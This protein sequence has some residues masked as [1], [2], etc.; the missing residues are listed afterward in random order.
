MKKFISVLAICMMLIMSVAISAFAAE[1]DNSFVLTVCNANSL[2]IEPVRVTYNDGQTIKDALLNSGYEFSGLAEHGYIEAVEGVSASYVILYDGGGY[3]VN[4]EASSIT[5]IRIGVTNVNSAATD[6]MLSMIK[7]VADFVDATNNVQNYPDAKSAYKNCLNAIRGDGL[8]AQTLL[9]ALEAAESAYTAVLNGPKFTVS[10]T[11]LQSGK[12]LPTPTVSLRDSYGNVTT[13]I[14][15]TVSVIAGNYTFSVSDG[16]YN[17]TEGK[18]TV[19]TNTSISTTLP[20]TEWYGDI[21]SEGYLYGETGGNYFDYKVEQD[22][23]N[24]TLKIWVYDFAEGRVGVRLKAV[25]KDVP[26]KDAQRSETGLYAVYTGF[27]GND[28]SQFNHGW[29]GMQNL[30]YVVEAGLE[31]RTFQLEGRYTNGSQT[32]IQSYDVEIIRVPTLTDIT[33]IGDGTILPINFNRKINDYTIATTANEVLVDVVKFDEDYIVTGAGS[34][35]LTDR[36]TD[37]SV[38]VTTPNGASATYSFTIEKRDAVSVVLDIPSDTDVTLCN[39]AEVVIQPVNGT[40]RLIPGEKYTYTA[41]K[42][43]Y[44]HTRESF[45][46]GDNLTVQVKAPN[47]NDWLEEF[48]L[49]N[50]KVKT[51]EWTYNW[52]S[53]DV[54]KE[55]TP[56]NHVYEYSIADTKSGIYTQANVTEGTPYALYRGQAI[57]VNEDG[58]DVKYEIASSYDLSDSAQFLYYG[59]R[60]CGYGQIITIRVTKTDGAVEYYQDY[61]L[62]IHRELHLKSLET[63]ANGNILLFVDE[64]GTKTEFDRDI[65][66]YRVKVDRGSQSI[67]LSGKFVNENST[68]ASDGGYYA[69]VNGVRYDALSDIEVPLNIDNDVD[70]IAIQVCHNDETSTPATYIVDVYKS[71]PVNVTIRTN[72]SEAVVFLT[73]DMSGRRIIGENGIFQLVP[74]ASYS[75]TVTCAGFVGQQ[76]SFTAPETDDTISVTLAAA[77]VNTNLRDLYA[78]W[79][80]L[81]LNNSNNGV[82]SVRSPIKAENAVLYW[83][84]M[85][86]TGFDSDACSPPIIV[87]GY[88]YVYAGARIFKIDTMSGAVVATGTMDHSSSFAIN[89]PTYANGMIFVGQSNGTIQAFNAATL[90]SLWIYRDAL[91][92]QPNCSIVYHDGYVYSG[93]WNGETMEANFVCLSATDEEPNNTKEEKL[94]TWKYASPGGFYWAGA[95]VCDDFVLVGTDDGQNGYTTGC[96]SLLSLDTKTGALLDKYTMNVTGDIRSSITCYNGKYYF[97]SKGGYFFEATVSDD[98]DITKVR[99]LKLYNHSNDATNPA[100]STCTPTIY[101]G[102]AYIGVSGTSQ[103]GAYSGHNISVIDINNWEIAYTVRTQGYPQTSGVLTT[104]YEQE[105]GSVY[106]YFFDNYT[107]GKL[108]VLEDKPGQVVPSL[109]TTEYT[110]QTAYN[111]F[112]PVGEQA[113]YALCSPVIDEYGTIYFKNDSAY[114]MAVGSTIEKLE[115]TKMPDKTAYTAGETFDATGM[116]VTAFYSNGLSRDV[117]NY[118]SWSKEPLTDDDTDFQ[119]S[120]PHVMYQNKD[121]KA[122]EEYLEPFAAVELQVDTDIMYGDVDGNEDVDMRDMSLIFQYMMARTD[123]SER[124]I[125]VAD[126]NGDDDVDMRDMSLIFKYMMGEI[127][128]F[129]V[130]Q[131]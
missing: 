13:Q 120:F 34:V 33:I 109:V 56:N 29:N 99:T 107:P 101:N 63:R 30:Q 16:S 86:G 73:D 84:N 50:G 128:Y 116:Q 79:P 122:G 9:S 52:R 96:P 131:K 49:F 36:Y 15:N 38:I 55:F 89:P 113:Q 39:A 57:G 71:D 40:Y 26:D 4:A 103:F 54:D 17:R 98:G 69:I 111:L 3:D 64:N 11:A 102:R 76:G 59:I 45:I 68:V 61:I 12:E 53:L 81:R 118:V 22:K 117:T 130:E 93:F 23:E 87:D 58:H 37:H 77:A 74:G 2:I 48:G 78:L 35:N 80:H 129:P 65:L 7:A 20:D 19:N 28:R 123:F 83:A 60:E 82:V 91:R 126:V 62:T 27:D 97:T 46:A 6:D 121:G 110:F 44:F 1:P 66:N 72:P 90:E 88:L 51:G 108:R 104:A 31:G 32:M 106:V 21:T 25:R 95:Y 47:T 127:D 124:Q 94:A 24:H 112:Q 41:T 92:G 67:T 115:I 125:V 119:I 75:Y 18:L 14:G 10:V 8:S 70:S 114:L 85:I 105:T 42:N 100:M 43:T 5:A